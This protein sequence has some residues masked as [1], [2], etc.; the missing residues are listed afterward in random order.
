[1]HLLL[2]FGT[3]VALSAFASTASAQSFFPEHNGVALI[4]ITTF[5][6][7]VRVLT[8]LN[9]D[10]DLE[11]FE[12]NANSEFV[13][14]LRRDGMRVESSAPNYVFCDIRLAGLV[15]GA[16]LAYA[17]DISFYDFTAGG[18]HVL[19]WTQGGVGTVGRDNFSPESTIE[20]CAD[21]LASEWLRW[22]PN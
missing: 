9:M 4:G 15:D 16:L 18:L 3:S 21:S 20:P 22:N 11:R 1:M 5:D 14:A 10:G 7:N 2:T 6:A 17:W 12:R 8:W 13:L 19:K